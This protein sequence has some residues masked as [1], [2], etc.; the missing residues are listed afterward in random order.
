MRNLF[1]F[2]MV[3]FLLA[4]CNQQSPDKVEEESANQQPATEGSYGEIIT[5]ENAVPVFRLK[6]MLADRDSVNVKL[7]GEI[8]AS[9][10]SSGCWMDL[11]ISDQD[12]LMVTFKDYAFEIPT[13]S[14]GKTTYIEGV[15]MKELIPVERLRNKAAEEG[16][17]R[18][19]I[20]AINEPKWAYTFEAK[21]VLIKDNE[22]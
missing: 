14:K 19:E 9:C 22:N 1:V 3:F 4:S 11:A 5:T 21:G 15:A 6:E 18:E 13:D 12:T 17:S 20:A 8:S 2:S 16:K 10:Q 7:T